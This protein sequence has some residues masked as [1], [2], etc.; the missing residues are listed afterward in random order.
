M[1]GTQKSEIWLLY[2][3]WSQDRKRKDLQIPLYRFPVPIKQDR[4]RS[5]NLERALTDIGINVRVS[6]CDRQTQQ[7]IMVK[8]TSF[9]ARFVCIVIY[10]SYFSSK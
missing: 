4:K 5:N 8:N 3:F 6:S 2:L 1:T 9:G 7:N 10:C